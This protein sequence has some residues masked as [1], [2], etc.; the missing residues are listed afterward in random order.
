MCAFSL[1]VVFLKNTKSKDG[2]LTIGPLHNN[3]PSNKI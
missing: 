3:Y 1:P 2:K